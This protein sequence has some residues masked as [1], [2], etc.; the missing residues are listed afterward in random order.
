[1]GVQL[2]NC[3]E[4]YLGLPS[5]VGRNKKGTFLYLKDKIKSCIESWSS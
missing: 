4:R 3:L 2:A 5:V 1:M